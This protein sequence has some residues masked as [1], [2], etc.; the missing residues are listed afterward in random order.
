MQG[1]GSLLYSIRP[2]LVFYNTCE[3]IDLLVAAVRRLKSGKNSYITKSEYFQRVTETTF[4][5][6]T[7]P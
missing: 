6:L 3:D 1:T 5:D 2:L 4:F 7:K